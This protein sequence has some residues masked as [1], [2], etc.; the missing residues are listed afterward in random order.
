MV[1]K[2]KATVIRS[3]DE[4]DFESVHHKKMRVLDYDGRTINLRI[5]RNSNNFHL[6]EHDLT[7][8]KK[9]NTQYESEDSSK[10]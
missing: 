1:T 3:S 9:Q 10:D 6:I 2:N 7:K 4:S 8:S 5:T